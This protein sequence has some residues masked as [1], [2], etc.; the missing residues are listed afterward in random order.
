MCSHYLDHWECVVLNE[1]ECKN[2]KSLKY[3]C[4]ACRQKAIITAILKTEYMNFESDMYLS[5]NSYINL[6]LLKYIYIHIC[7]HPYVFEGSILARIGLKTTR[8]KD[9]Y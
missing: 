5:E 7:I 6:T 4:F 9:C 1:I 8:C 2:P 3:Q